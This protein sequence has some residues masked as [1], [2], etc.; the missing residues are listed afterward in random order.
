MY[1]NI[2]LKKQREKIIL[3][4]ILTELNWENGNAPNLGN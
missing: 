4:L 2:E 1:I 3:N